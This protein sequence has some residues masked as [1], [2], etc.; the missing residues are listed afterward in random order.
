MRIYSQGIFDII[1]AE[2]LRIPRYKKRIDP[3]T[4]EDI[5]DRVILVNNIREF[6]E[7]LY[8]LGKVYDRNL[9]LGLVENDINSLNAFQKLLDYENFPSDA[10]RENF[11]V[12]KYLR[13][14]MY[15][16]NTGEVIKAPD[17]VGVF[18]PKLKRNI[19]TKMDFKDFLLYGLSGYFADFNND[20][21]DDKYRTEYNE[22]YKEKLDSI[23]I[24]LDTT[25]LETV[26][27]K[28]IYTI[29]DLDGDG[30]EEFINNII[31]KDEDNNWG[32]Y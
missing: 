8:K 14:R 23:T 27:E 30:I 13:E 15:L 32:V 21:T 24:S 4:Y 3:L 19:L 28:R 25:P 18:E 6:K 22:Y 20:R 11:L 29:N 26:A 5:D 16:D 31:L 12:N 7:G 9:V 10:V 1:T 17:S 2:E